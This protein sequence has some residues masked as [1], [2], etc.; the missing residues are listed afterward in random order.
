MPI[1]AKPR[2]H[3]LILDQGDDASS[4]DTAMAVAGQFGLKPD[5]ARNIAAEVGVA[6]LAWRMVAAD[7]G[8]TGSQI[9]RMASAFEHEDLAKAVA[10]P[11]GVA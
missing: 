1:D 7:N 9:E 10:L 5:A 11:A 4:I 2:H 6:V 3:A 8:L